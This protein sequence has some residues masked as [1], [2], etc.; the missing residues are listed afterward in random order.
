LE[1]MHW[2]AGVIERAL[3]TPNPWSTLAEKFW[4]LPLVA[5]V[6]KLSEERADVETDLLSLYRRY[7]DEWRGFPVERA[8][9]AEPLAA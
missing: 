8:T 7:V 6:V 3:A 1:K 9:T 4:M 2:Q 5:S